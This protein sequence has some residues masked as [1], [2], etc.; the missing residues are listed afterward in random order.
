MEFCKL[1]IF[2]WQKLYIE[3]CIKWQKRLQIPKS[4]TVYFGTFLK[5]DPKIRKIMHFQTAVEIALVDGFWWNLWQMEALGSYFRGKYEFQIFD[6]FTMT[7]SYM[8]TNHIRIFGNI[9]KYQIWAM[10]ELS[11]RSEELIFSKFFSRN[12]FYQP[13]PGKCYHQIFYIYPRSRAISFWKFQIFRFPDFP[14]FP[15]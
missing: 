2:K 12:F 15:I 4:K 14:D 11:Y 5:I 1:V 10:F 9:E 13:M 8:N 7:Y 6:H 3:F